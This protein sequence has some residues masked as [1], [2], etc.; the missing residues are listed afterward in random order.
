M[1][2]AYRPE[3][4]RCLQHPLLAL[5]VRVRLSERGSVIPSGDALLRAGSDDAAIDMHLSHGAE[6]TEM[7]GGNACAH[8]AG[9]GW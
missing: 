2:G 8:D 4:R 5:R 3:L 6:V 9:G 7:D 1:L